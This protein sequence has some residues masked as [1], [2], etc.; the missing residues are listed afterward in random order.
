MEQASNSRP[1]Q[2][3]ACDLARS[4]KT[5]LSD[6]AQCLVNLPTHNIKSQQSILH[7]LS[8][9]YSVSRH[10][11]Y[12]TMSVS[13]DNIQ[14]I[15]NVIFGMLATGIGIITVRQGKTFLTK[16]RMLAWNK[17]ASSGQ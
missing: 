5:L 9:T 14:I 13:S 6:L 1:R 4:T 7:F 12:T 10:L 8:E 11:L 17:E 2:V 15:V 3:P 16:N